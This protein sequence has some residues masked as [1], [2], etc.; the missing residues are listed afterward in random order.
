MNRTSYPSDLTDAQ[1]EKLSPFL[2]TPH[3][4]GR[5]LKWEMCLI[6][7][8]IV[9]VVKSGCQWRMLPHDM[10][11]WQTVY[12]RLLPFQKVE[13]RRYMALDSSGTSRTNTS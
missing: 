8:A 3:P 11:P 9:Y 1:W 7:N 10:P 5:P 6:I 4:L 12:Y 2:P 13:S